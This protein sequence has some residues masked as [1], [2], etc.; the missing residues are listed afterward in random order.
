MKLHGR[1]S[2][3]DGGDG[4]DPSL[5]LERQNEDGRRLYLVEA[6]NRDELYTQNPDNDVET[7]LTELYRASRLAFEE[8][9]ANI[10]Y[11]CLGFLKWKALRKRSASIA[12]RSSSSPSSWSAAASARASAPLHE[13]EIRFNPTLSRCSNAISSSDMPECR[14]ELPASG[15]TVDIARHL[16]DRTPGTSGTSETSRSPKG[17]CSPPCPSQSI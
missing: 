11:L 3:L 17:L 16:E 10:L 13:D 8:G 9:G 4:R 14:S 1:A 7:H 2:V 12:P 6:L 15:P 5:V